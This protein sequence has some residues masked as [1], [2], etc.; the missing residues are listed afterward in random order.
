VVVPSASS[1]D[2]I[3]SL[4]GQVFAKAGDLNIQLPE[5][6]LLA[7]SVAAWDGSDTAGTLVRIY[8]VVIDVEDSNQRTAW[9]RGE[10]VATEGGGFKLLLPAG[11]ALLQ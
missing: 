9:L 6:A 7:G 8:E 2:P 5:A 11:A 1:A 3:T 10:A 4:T